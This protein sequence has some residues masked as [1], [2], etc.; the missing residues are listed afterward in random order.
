MGD[1]GVGEHAAK[2]VLE[3]REDVA[4]RHGD[5]G[6]DPQE[7]RELHAE[8]LPWKDLRVAGRQDVA[9]HAEQGGEADDLGDECE[10]CCHGQRGAL[11]DIRRIEVERD[12][13][14][15]EAKARDDHD[16]REKRYAHPG[17]FASSIALA[18]EQR[19]EDGGD[20]RRASQAVEVAESEEHEG[21]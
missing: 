3:Q 15:P 11:I 16:D 7:H 13:R 1:A 14:D 10:Q 12:C 17:K 4:K 9:Q 5:G 18:V 8:R 6:H 2:V 19:V 20:V 21:R